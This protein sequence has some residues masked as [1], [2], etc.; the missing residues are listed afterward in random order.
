[1]RKRKLYLAAVGTW[2]VFLV[3]A[4]SLAALRELALTPLMGEK[5]AHVV[6]TL[7]VIAVFLGIMIV[8]VR[9]FRGRCSACDF[10]WIGLM[11]LL[12]TASFELLFFHYVGGKSWSE[13]LADYNVLAGRIWVL[14]LATTLFGP[15]AVHAMLRRKARDP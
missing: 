1:M 2:V 11:W 8:F 4:F 6:G 9:R 12:M 13:L 14:V 15:P 7:A 10:W 5:A 3:V